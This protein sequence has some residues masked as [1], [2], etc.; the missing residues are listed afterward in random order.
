V[1]EVFSVN[2][3]DAGLSHLAAQSGL[4]NF[5]QDVPEAEKGKGYVE[6]KRIDVSE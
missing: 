3:N 1:K 6:V 4:Y 5:A 2:V